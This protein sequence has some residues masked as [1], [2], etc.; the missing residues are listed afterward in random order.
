[1]SNPRER[2][3]ARRAAVQAL[4]QWQITNQ[5]TEE[6][7][8]QFR[9]ERLLNRCDVAY[10]HELLNSIPPQLAKLN[11]HLEPCLDRPLK[12]LDPVERAILQIGTFE[13]LNRDDVPS[14]VVINEAVELAKTF[15][16]EDSHKY[17][18]GI[19]DRIARSVRP[20]EALSGH[21][22]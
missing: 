21:N 16:A 13:L 2:H 14:R 8:A 18:N 5:D 15:G 20:A 9:A 19:L 6:I 10:F 17:V 7:D 1:M 12:Q 11:R 22:R 3:R 4:Y